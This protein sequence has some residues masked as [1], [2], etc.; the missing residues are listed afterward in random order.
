MYSIRK[1]TP[2]LKKLAFKIRQKCGLCSLGENDRKLISIDRNLSL[3]F[4]SKSY[5]QKD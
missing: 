1:F 3:R 2:A 4:C 5:K